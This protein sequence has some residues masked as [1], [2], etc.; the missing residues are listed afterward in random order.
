MNNYKIS[1]IVLLYNPSL[2]DLY[3]TLASIIQQK[4]FIQNVYLKYCC[5]AAHC[6]NQR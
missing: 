4:I 3:V 6:S 2:D 1:V 5:F